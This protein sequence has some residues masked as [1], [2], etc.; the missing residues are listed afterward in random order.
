[1]Q[2]ESEGGSDT[3]AVRA[4]TAINIGSHETM[5]VEAKV[6]SVLIV[7]EGGDRASVAIDVTVDLLPLQIPQ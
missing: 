1:M 5:D 7:T 6:T 3:S 2:R 4:P